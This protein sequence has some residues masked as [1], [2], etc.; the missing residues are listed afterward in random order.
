V[1]LTGEELQLG[2][3]AIQFGESLLPHAVEN[4]SQPR[5]ALVGFL[6]AAA[7]L[8]VVFAK[9]GQ[10]NARAVFISQASA[11]FDDEWRRREGS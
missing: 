9:K 8:A 5:V 7:K 3:E 2:T 1:K 6:L 4:T 11:A 10:P